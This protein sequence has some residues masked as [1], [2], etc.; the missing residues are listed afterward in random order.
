MQSG[1]GG[2]RRK[3]RKAANL[4]TSPAG[5]PE[6]PW[7]WREERGSGGRAGGEAGVE[8]AQGSF[9][10]SGREG[11]REGAEGAAGLLSACLCVCVLPGSPA[12]TQASA[13]H[14]AGPE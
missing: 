4:G 13:A 6:C 5:H 8:G 7:Q 12:Q 11:V 9:P 3:R 14:S 10:S 1:A 2:A